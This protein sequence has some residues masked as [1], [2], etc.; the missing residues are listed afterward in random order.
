MDLSQIINELGENHE[1]YFNAIAP[2]IIQ[3]SN[4]LFSSVAD[5]RNAM[6][7][8]Y[9]VNLYSRGNNPTLT[10]LRKKLAA[11]DSAEDAIV[12]SSGAAATFL[13]VFSNVKAGDHIVCVAKPYSWTDKLLN[14]L[15]PRF[16]VQTT[17][18]DG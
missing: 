4:F 11:L 8:E 17:M 12:L 1:E 18:V 16:N 14:S 3:T 13:A 6:Q 15:L 9:K 7:D 10:I 2:P 5:F